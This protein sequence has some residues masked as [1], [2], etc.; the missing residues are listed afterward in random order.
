MQIKQF[1]IPLNHT[2]EREFI[3]IVVFRISNTNITYMYFQEYQRFQ[4]K[5]CLTCVGVLNRLIAFSTRI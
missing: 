3:L 4:R 2:Y 5:A 1:L